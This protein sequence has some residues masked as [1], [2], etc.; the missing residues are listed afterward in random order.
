MHH[1]YGQPDNCTA[2][3]WWCERVV[4]IVIV[5]LLLRHLIAGFVLVLLLLRV[6]RRD[7]P[8]S[9][10]SIFTSLCIF[11]FF[12][13]QEHLHVNVVKSSYFPRDLKSAIREAY[14]VTDKALMQVNNINK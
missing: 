9:A 5:L 14:A 12:L 6:E 1:A 3:C 7:A 10:F 8:R 13:L 4:V 11:V 2:L